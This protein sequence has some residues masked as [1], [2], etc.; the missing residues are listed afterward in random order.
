M[1]TLLG[2]LE[3][4]YRVQNLLNNLKFCQPELTLQ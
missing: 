1:F 4:F 2:T 3:R